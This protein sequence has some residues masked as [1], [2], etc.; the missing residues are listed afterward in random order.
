MAR[1]KF[2]VLYNRPL[3]GVYPTYDELHDM[4]RKTENPY[5]RGF[6]TLADANTAL[7]LYNQRESRRRK[8]KVKSRIDTSGLH[9]V[10]FQIDTPE[11]FE[12]KKKEKESGKNDKSTN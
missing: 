2:Y 12:R 11:E 1:Y 7:E 6:H 10:I 9:K 4:I 8:P 5:F 3:Q